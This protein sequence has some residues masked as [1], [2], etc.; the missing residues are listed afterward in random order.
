MW[1]SRLYAINMFFV[2][3]FVLPLV[4]KE[5]AS[6]I[7]GQNIARL[8]EMYRE[9]RWSDGVRETLCSS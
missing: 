4:D 5:A 9:S 7:L 8:E 3:L 1:D 2:C 6:A